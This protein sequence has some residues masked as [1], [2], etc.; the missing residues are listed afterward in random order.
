MRPI[1]LWF[2][3]RAVASNVSDVGPPL[4][5]GQQLTILSTRAERLLKVGK[6]IFIAGGVLAAL[7]SAFGV[8]G[9]LFAPSLTISSV[10]LPDVL[11]FQF[12]DA[13]QAVSVTTTGATGGGPFG[14]PVAA[15]MGW[16]TGSFG[17][18]I[19]FGALAVGLAM[20][21]LRQ[22]IMPVVT[23]VAAAISIGIMPG[24]LQSMTAA[25]GSPLFSNSDTTYTRTEYR[26]SPRDAFRS[27]IS[28]KKWDEALK[29]IADLKDHG[30]AAGQ[31]VTAQIDI[32]RSKI[33]DAEGPL[34]VVESSEKTLDTSGSSA[35][36]LYAMDMTVFRKPQSAR[37]RWY[38]KQADG[39]VALCSHVAGFFAQGV[40]VL[41][42]GFL[43][44]GGFGR[45]LRKRVERV[46]ELALVHDIDLGEDLLPDLL[47]EEQSVDVPG[48]ICTSD[49]SV[50]V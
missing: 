47:P 45:S 1:T 19:A 2:R 13:A 34:H 3:R 11:L 36:I 17:T 6:S 27:L 33:K 24:F 37:A 30:G 14:A 40:E 48:E 23:G 35:K 18:T 16:M 4:T 10:T 20:A 25:S 7:G 50:R 8:A 12:S 15:I 21:F 5:I 39:L 9:V 44:F 43:V 31:Y 42:V 22:S 41:I 46:R 49:V 32:L 38:G 29:T 26:D 28:D